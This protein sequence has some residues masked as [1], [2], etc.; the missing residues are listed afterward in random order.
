MRQQGPW[1]AGL[2]LGLAL[3]DD[4]QGV[5]NVAA[6]LALKVAIDPELSAD[7]ETEAA[8]NRHRD[9][10]S[11][12]ERHVDDVIDGAVDCDDPL[13]GTMLEASDHVRVE[14]DVM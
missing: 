13:D 1:R 9:V 5:G 12:T 2:A 10:D 4:D 7:L 11:L 3:S 8:P 14:C 6:P